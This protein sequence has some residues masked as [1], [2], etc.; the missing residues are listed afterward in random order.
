MTDDEEEDLEI[1]LDLANSQSER[2]DESI[3]RL[4]RKHGGVIRGMLRKTFGSKLSKEEVKEVLFRT[5]TR[6]WRYAGSY[7]DTKAKLSTW[8]VVIAINQARNLLKE[9][10]A[11][12]ALV[13]DEFLA[14]QFAKSDVEEKP[15]R[16]DKKIIRDLKLVLSRL[17]TLQRAIIEADLACGGTAGGKR[18][19]ELHGTSVNSIYVSRKKAHD[20]IQTE[21]KKMGHFDPQHIPG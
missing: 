2:R 5:A 20:K 21:M 7:D 15:T 16:E 13:D 11:G 17:P 3:G 6:A 8:L 9:N 12:F 14:M 4:L 1:M 18:L 10:Q 19:A